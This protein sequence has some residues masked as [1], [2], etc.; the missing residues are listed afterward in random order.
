MKTDQS[1]GSFKVIRRGRCGQSV[2]DGVSEELISFSKVVSRS[3]KDGERSPVIGRSLSRSANQPPRLPDPDW[4]V[5]G[6]G[7]LL[8]FARRDSAETTTTTTVM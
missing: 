2:N 8:R 1:S 5:D 7:S 3:V 4:S 6:G